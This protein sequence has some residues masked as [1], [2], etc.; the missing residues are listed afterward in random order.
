VQAL[1]PSPGGVGGGEFIFGWLYARV[2]PSMEPAGVLASLGKLIIGW[3]LGLVGY[4][5]Y[6]RMRPCLRSE[7]E[8]AADVMTQPPLAKASHQR[9]WPMSFPGAPDG[10]GAGPDHKRD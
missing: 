5:V 6:L 7:A 8:L 2:D 3:G 4:F 10:K 9:D 1:F